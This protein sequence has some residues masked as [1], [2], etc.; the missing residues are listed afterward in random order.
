MIRIYPAETDAELEAWRRVR[1][2]VLP[3][4]RAASV[5][6]MRRTH[7][8]DRLMLLA[9]L[10]GDVVGSAVEFEDV[11]G[12]VFLGLK[13]FGLN[14]AELRTKRV[15]DVVGSLALLVVAAPVLLVCAIVIKL[16]SRGPVIFRQERIGRDGEVSEHRV[17][18]EDAVELMHQAQAG[19]VA[20][21]F[22]APHVLTAKPGKRLAGLI[23]KS[24]EAA[25]TVAAAEIA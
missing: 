1:I 10:D 21:G 14:R 8:A 4:E 9:E 2:A 22:P 15:M 13:R 23:A 3:N 18:V 7:T 20:A 24:Q 16:D 5:E 17:G 19:L 25:A 6:E 11:H 12:D